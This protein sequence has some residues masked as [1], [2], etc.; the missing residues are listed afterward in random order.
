[1][2][3]LPPGGQLYEVGLGFWLQL[4]RMQITAT[5]VRA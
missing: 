3:A 4:T 5:I 2:T 1:V